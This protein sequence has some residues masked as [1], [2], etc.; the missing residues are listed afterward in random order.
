M[1]IKE[2]FRVTHSLFDGNHVGIMA[3]GVPS[4]YVVKNRFLIGGLLPFQD[5]LYRGI[6]MLECTGYQVEENSFT[7]AE[8]AIGAT[9]GIDI[10]DSGDE[11]NLIYRNNF[12]N[13]T[14]ANIAERENQASNPIFGL[15]YQC[16]QNEEN[17]LDFAVIE[18]AT[19]A[20]NQGNVQE[21]AGNSFTESSPM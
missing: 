14:F 8:E 6:E 20:I 19:I 21:S 12:V 3:E 16:N 1:T 15:Q 10:A 11:P 5:N 2:T 17:G 13:I 7:R 18:S 4:A 9:L